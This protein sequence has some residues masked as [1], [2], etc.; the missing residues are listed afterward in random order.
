VI[1]I[2]LFLNVFIVLI[3]SP[4]RADL[5]DSYSLTTLTVE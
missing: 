2:V 4:C 1:R 3:P 5:K